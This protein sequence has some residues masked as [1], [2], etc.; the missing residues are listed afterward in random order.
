MDKARLFHLKI[1]CP[2]PVHCEPGNHD[3]NGRTIEKIGMVHSHLAS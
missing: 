2:Y 1:N 3:K